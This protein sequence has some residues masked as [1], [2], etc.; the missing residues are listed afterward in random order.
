MAPAAAGRG[1]VWAGADVCALPARAPDAPLFGWRLATEVVSEFAG[2][3]LFTAVGS[4]ARSPALTNGLALAAV[5]FALAPVSGAKLNPTVS[6]AAALADVARADDSWRAKRAAASVAAWRF[7]LEAGAQFAGA[8]A[9][10]AVARK[11]AQPAGV[12]IACFTPPTGTSQTVVGVNEARA[13]RASTARAT[14]APARRR[15]R[16]R[17]VWAPRSSC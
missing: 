1:G 12:S 16:R 10:V 6:A 14:A 13:H 3:L 15:S 2:T 4:S 9:G 8:F 11:M 5:V 17:R 7:A